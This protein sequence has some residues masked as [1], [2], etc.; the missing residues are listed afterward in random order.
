M[1]ASPAEKRARD[2]DRNFIDYIRK[3]REK[4]KGMYVFGPGEVNAG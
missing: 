2:I 3:G 4:A 1:T